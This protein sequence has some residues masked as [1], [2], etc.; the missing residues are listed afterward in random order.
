MR[1]TIEV[2]WCPRK[3][4]QRAII[5]TIMQFWKKNVLEKI[6]FLLKENDLLSPRRHIVE[7]KNLC[8]LL[9]NVKYPH[10]QCVLD[11]F[12]KEIIIS[13]I[14]F[15]LPHCSEQFLMYGDVF[16][17][18]IDAKLTILYCNNAK[19]NAYRN[20]KPLLTLYYLLFWNAEKTRFCTERWCNKDFE[21][22]FS[23]KK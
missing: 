1:T 21:L 8:F 6:F 10:K 16:K 13:F 15:F 4:S 7:V 20:V 22:I 23:A 5:R 19:I 3:G 18:I 14:G 17:C 9:K 2:T 12:K 11:H